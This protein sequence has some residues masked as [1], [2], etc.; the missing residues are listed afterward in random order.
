MISQTLTIPQSDVRRLLSAAS[1]DAALLYLYINTGN[2]PEDAAREL[3]MN[4]ARLQCAGAT[5]RQLGLWPEV[6]PSHIA[7]GERPS[8]S[9]QD[10]L[11]A[12]DSDLDFRGLYG[13]VQRLLG[14]SL[15]TE[16]LKILL[17]FVRYLGLPGDVISVLVCYCKERARQRGNS[18]NPSLRTI[19]KEAYAWAEQGIDTV[20]EAAAFISAQNVRNSRLRRLMD[21]L[22]IRGRSLTAAE[23]KYA[24]RWLDMG[25]EEELIA[26]AYERTCLNTGGLNWAYM[27]KILQRWND[28]GLRTA[29]AVR[30]GDQKPVPKGASGQLGEAE[31]AFIQRAMKE[32]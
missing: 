20:E 18:R 2:R 26:M 4:D 11:R 21:Q 15:N 9:E 31:L 10:V 14:R 7:P 6:R 12:M 27:N 24:L 5:L 23:E 17:G 16:E 32:G 13:E 19:E 28:Q 22:Q 3:N 30:S 8:Y 29:E 1:P 25:I